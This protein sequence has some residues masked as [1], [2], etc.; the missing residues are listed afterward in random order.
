[1][2]NPHTRCTVM[3][4]TLCALLT[5]SQ[6]VKVS[7][8]LVNGRWRKAWVKTGMDTDQNPTV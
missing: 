2:V 4:L 7:F 1:M 5:P 8:T 6:A 3:G